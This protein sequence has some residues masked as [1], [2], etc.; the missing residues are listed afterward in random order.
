MPE[1]TDRAR[2]IHALRAMGER[3]EPAV[4]ALIEAL[5]LENE[6]QAKTVAMTLAGIG[7]AAAEALPALRLLH[8][9]IGEPF[10]RS[11]KVAIAK[12]ERSVEPSSN[13]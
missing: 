13:R 1:S 12:I 9:R 7:P 4:P 8:A 11:V 5:Q 10:R 6:V 2:A 3:A